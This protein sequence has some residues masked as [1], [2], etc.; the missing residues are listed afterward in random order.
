MTKNRAIK[1]LAVKVGSNVLANKDG[2]LDVESMTNLTRQ[3]SELSETGV[4]IILISSG[5]VAS[6]KSIFKPNSKTDNVGFRQMWSSLGQVKMIQTYADLFG[7]HG[8]MCAQVLVTKEDFRSRQHYLNIKNC[9]T[10]L[11]K[12]GIIPIVNENDVVSV[13]ELMFTDN[14]ELAGLVSTMLDVDGLYILTN[15]DG[16]LKEGVGSKVI[17]EIR[18]EHKDLEKYIQKGKSKFGRGGMLTKI[19][20]ARK[21]AEAGI[22]VKIANGR[23]ENIIFNLINNQARCTKFISTSGKSSIKKWLAHTEGYE[24]GAVT[25]NEGAVQA[26][27]S[28]KA[29]SILPVGVVE[30]AGNFEKG[31]VIKIFSENGGEIGVGMARYSAEKVR[32]KM[33]QQQQ[34]PVVHYDYLFLK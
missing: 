10:V 21:V 30:V 18:P 29:V 4:E 3:L 13:T 32:K 6:G 7:K 17:E 9:F 22:E 28:E 8:L 20:M 33:G 27:R 12:N 15:V 19:H 14:D 34:R 2:L 11:L 1:R 23:N 26:L 5:A 25:M 16:V 31:D 24:K